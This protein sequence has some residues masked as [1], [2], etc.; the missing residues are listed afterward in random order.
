MDLESKYSLLFKA[1]DWVDT[2]WFTYDYAQLS[3]VLATCIFDFSR[4][5][6]F[7]YLYKTEGGC[8]GKPPWNNVQTALCGLKFFNKGKS[9]KSVLALMDECYNISNFK[10]KPSEALYI[11]ASHYAQAGNEK[12]SQISNAKRYLKSF[13]TEH[14]MEILESCR[15]ADSLPPE[16]LEKS[17]IV[18]VKDK[19]LGSAIAEMRKNG[20]VMTEL[21]VQLKQLGRLKFSD[22]LKDENM[23]SVRKRREKEKEEIKR[24]GFAQIAKFSQVD[25]LLKNIEEQAISIMAKYYRLKTDIS[26]MSSLTYAGILRVFKTADVEEYFRQHSFGLSDEIITGISMLQNQNLNLKTNRARSD[27][28]YQIEWMTSGTLSELFEGEVPPSLGSD[29]ARLGR[30]LLRFLRQ[31]ELGEYPVVIVIITGDKDL[32]MSLNKLIKRRDVSVVGCSVIDYIR[33]CQKLASASKVKVF[34]FL[35][36]QETGM[37]GIERLIRSSASWFQIPRI[38]YKILFDYPNVNRDL[39]GYKAQKGNQIGKISGGFLKRRTA[40]TTQYSIMEWEEFKK[41]KDFERTVKR[42]TI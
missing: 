19:L 28:S 11:N 1:A 6:I 34:N 29:D 9:T 38:G 4:A 42:F 2:D 15:G 17:V 25:S 13:D 26:D 33:D 14:R 18:E 8:G 35:R 24:N 39:L 32:I 3:L 23:G 21:D 16:L 36:G 12:L 20:L 10:I 27:L 7:P 37:P 40:Q 5:R 30:K 41:L 22:L 31:T